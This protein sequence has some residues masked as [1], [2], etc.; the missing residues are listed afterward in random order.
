M[1]FDKDN[2]EE[3]NELA[4]LEE[5]EAGDVDEVAGVEMRERGRRDTERRARAAQAL[6]YRTKRGSAST[7]GSTAKA[8]AGKGS[9]PVWWREE[10]RQGRLPLV[11]AKAPPRNRRRRNP[12]ARAEKASKKPA[13]KAAAAAREKE[14]LSPPFVETLHPES[15]SKERP[16]I[17]GLSFGLPTRRGLPLFAHKHAPDRQ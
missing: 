15:C 10:V 3:D 13:K 4:P 12:A 7:S 8:S 17:A 1:D 11:K 5:E 2:F 6:C 9:E 14:T 16:V